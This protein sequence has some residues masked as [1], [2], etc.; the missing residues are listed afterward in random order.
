MAVQQRYWLQSRISVP[1]QRKRPT[2]APCP[3]PFLLQRKPSGF[4][5][6]HLSPEIDTVLG[7]SPQW[8]ILVCDA[9]QR[10]ALL[11]R[12]VCD[13]VH[14]DFY[15]QTTNYRED[16]EEEGAGSGG[17]WVHPEEDQF[18]G[19]IISTRPISLNTAKWSGN[20]LHYQDADNASR[21][22]PERSC[23]WPSLVRSEVRVSSAGI[24]GCLGLEPLTIQLKDVLSSY[25]TKLRNLGLNCYG[26]PN[27]L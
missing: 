2:Q 20:R 24:D 12:A 15:I 17:G 4:L 14:P 13:R 8:Q 3:V 23:S 1:R 21:S 26:Q 18:S 25:Q 19:V 5:C 22:F 16:W 6:Q 9:W 27:A 10:T 11:W 7:A